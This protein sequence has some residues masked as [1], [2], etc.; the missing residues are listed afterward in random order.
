MAIPNDDPLNRGRWVYCT[1]VR[2]WR[3]GKY[4]YPKKS[5]FFR[6]RFRK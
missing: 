4:I 1:R 3:T 2:H 6:F 5:R